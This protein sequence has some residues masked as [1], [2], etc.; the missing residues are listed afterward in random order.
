ML[1]FAS[2]K[3]VSEELV[4][5]C[6]QML[7]VL[8]APGNPAEAKLMCLLYQLFLFLTFFN[9]EIKS[10][11]S[12]LLPRAPPPYHTHT[13]ISVHRNTKPIYSQ[14]YQLVREH[15]RVFTKNLL[16]VQETLHKMRWGG[17][18]SSKGS[19]CFEICTYILIFCICVN[20][21][22]ELFDL[23]S[24]CFAEEEMSSLYLLKI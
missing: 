15:I 1:S 23:G 18:N 2:P 6:L 22:L 17:G 16:D 14:R 12:P 10:T 21:I 24:E 8:F 4:T 3:V 7:T 11:K 19:V 5:S 20:L 9:R 13:Q